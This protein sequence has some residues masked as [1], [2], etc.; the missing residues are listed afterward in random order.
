MK[1]DFLTSAEISLTGDHGYIHAG[2][3]FSLPVTISALAAAGVSNIGFTT[4]DSTPGNPQI[5]WRPTEFSS[6]A[7]SARV[8][9]YQGSGGA[10]GANQEIVLEP[11]TS[12]V[13]NVV[14][15][16]SATATDV[17]LNLFYYEEYY[18]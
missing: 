4:P 9:L 1:H 18:Q 16:G 11:N 2:Y 15:T 8:R 14:N 12:Y 3:A 10:G 6:S 5:H 17:D 7:N 13:L